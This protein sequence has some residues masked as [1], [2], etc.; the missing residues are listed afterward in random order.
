MNILNGYAF[1]SDLVPISNGLINRNY[2][3]FMME[4]IDFNC[5]LYGQAEF[6]KKFNLIKLKINES[7]LDLDIEKFKEKWNIS[8]LECE[9][10]SFKKKIIDFY[11]NKIII[12]Q[13][14]EKNKE[15]YDSFCENINKILN[16]LNLSDLNLKTLLL[17]KMENYYEFLELDSL[18]SETSLLNKEYNNIKDCIDKLK[19]DTPICN[20][21][22]TE[23]VSYF[24]Y[25][26]GHTFC[27][28]CKLKCDTSIYCHYCRTKKEDVK[29]LYL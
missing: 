14:F 1:D 9:I 12:E 7:D 5:Q 13:K 28:R 24:I 10:D 18:I 20:I 6:L 2:D 3:E 23:P 17:K 21:C 8:N 15:L 4:R 22:M 26:C 19:C 11:D 29:K 25:P 16:S 27:E